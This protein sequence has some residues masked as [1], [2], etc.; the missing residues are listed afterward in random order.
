MH[1]DDSVSADEFCLH[2]RVEASFIQSLEEYGLVETTVVKDACLL[3][4]RQ[5]AELERLVRLHYNL[6]I[7]FEGLQAVSHLLQQ[8]E[9][10]QTE[11]N[12]LKNRLRLYEDGA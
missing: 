10:L 3:P 6:H 9:A 11:I 8:T 5:L 2:H 1:R 12:R 7:N 4:T